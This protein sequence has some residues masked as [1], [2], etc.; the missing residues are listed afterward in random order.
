MHPGIALSP[1]ASLASEPSVAGES[2]DESC[3]DAASGN[4]TSNDASNDG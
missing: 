4:V 2:M 1:P 3:G